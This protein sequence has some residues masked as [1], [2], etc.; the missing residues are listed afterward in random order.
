MSIQ[1]IEIRQFQGPATVEL[2][3]VGVPEIVEVRQGPAGLNGPNSVTSATTSDGTCDLSVLTLDATQGIGAGLNPTSGRSITANGGD[4]TG[5]YVSATS[6]TGL[7]IEVDTGIALD[8]TSNTGNDIATFRDELNNGLNIENPRGWITWVYEPGDIYLGRL[9]TADITANRDWTLPDRTGNIALTEDYTA[10][11]ATID[12]LNATVQG[13]L[14]AAH[15]HGNVA[16]SVYAHV[17]AGENL[18]KGDPVYV[19]GSHG[20]GANLIAVVSKADAS[21]AAKMPAVGV[22]DAAVSN[23]ANGHMVITGTISDIDTNAYAVNSVLYVASGGGFTTTPPVANSQPV[24]IVERSN[25]NNGAVIVKVN[26]L[27]SSGGNGASDANK[28]ARYSSAGTLPIASIGGLG[29]NVATFLAT[30]TSANLAAAVTG[31]TGTGALVFANSPTFSGT[32]LIGA[33]IILSENGFQRAF[34]S[35]D[36]T[37]ATT[38]TGNKIPSFSISVESGK[39]YKLEIML[40]VTGVAGSTHNS[41][42]VGSFNLTAANSSMMYRRAGFETESFVLGSTPFS[43][44]GLFNSTGTSSQICFLDGIIK[45]TSSG[46]L[47]VVLYSS[48]ATNSVTMLKGAYMEATL[49]D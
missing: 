34:L 28:L 8:V 15:I 33:K 44:F 12:V 5:I 22:M 26:G 6:G 23:N 48:S 16:G 2:S 10:G 9:Q 40:K 7:L 46:V 4:G 30:P 17:R 11:T 49:L 1:I 3:G 14:T 36:Y 18:A 24:A 29:S 32:P 43:G 19:S 35:S 20:T 27:A 42:L 47:E 31:E 41:T 37:I 25:T 21:N 39:T 45:P 13:T 38:N